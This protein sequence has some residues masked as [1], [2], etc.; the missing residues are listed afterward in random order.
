MDLWRSIRAPPPPYAADMLTTS[1]LIEVIVSGQGQINSDPKT[2]KLPRVL[3]CS[4][5]DYFKKACEWKARAG[6]L[7]ST[8]LPDIQPWVFEVFVVYIFEQRL[9]Q[10][11]CPALIWTTDEVSDRETPK[12]AVEDQSDV[13]SKIPIS[14]INNDGDGEEDLND[15]TTWNFTALFELAIFGDIYAG[16]NFRQAVFE[17]VQLRINMTTVDGESPRYA[18]YDFGSLTFAL[19][20]LPSS[21]KLRQYLIDTFAVQ[22]AGFFQRGDRLN[23]VSYMKCLQILPVDV[24]AEVIIKKDRMNAHFRCPQCSGKVTAQKCEAEDH[25]E[26][27]HA[28]LNMRGLC[29]YH[30][31]ETEAEKMLCKLRFQALK[32]RINP[33]LS[34]VADLA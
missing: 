24:L 20:R 1:E 15:P 4:H 30:E 16:P 7:L 27:D 2:F 22:T 14:Y 32:G 5:S 26:Y 23:E 3:L 9:R 19:R 8:E 28:E 12:Y 10:V 6:E 25:E 21:S 33:S 34:A 31:H 18:L 17:A 11:E 29:F 13:S